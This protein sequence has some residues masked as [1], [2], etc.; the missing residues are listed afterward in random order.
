VA[1]YQNKKETLKV[2]K[3]IRKLRLENNFLEDDIA[4]MTGFAKTTISSIEDGSNT[5]TSHL[6]EIAKAIGVHPM[7]LFNVPFE[8]KPRHKL[9]SNKVNRVFL[10]SRIK[11][12]VKSDFFKTPKLVKDVV[13]FLSEEVNLKIDSTKVSVILKRQFD[14]GKLKYIKQGRKNLYSKKGK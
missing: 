8:I 11:T 1:K 4:F 5:D 6:I 10:T 12:L 3:Q 2:G 13:E 7:E 14:E 9:P